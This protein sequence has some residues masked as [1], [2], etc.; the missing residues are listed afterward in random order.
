MLAPGSN[1]LNKF[2]AS[3]HISASLGEVLMSATLTWIAVI[4]ME[5]GKED[6]KYKSYNW[7][8]INKLLD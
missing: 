7:L 5:K 2:K 6:K 3:V 4:L 1:L 8:S